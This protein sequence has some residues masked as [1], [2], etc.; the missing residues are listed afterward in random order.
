VLEDDPYAACQYLTIGAQ[1]EVGRIAGGD[2]T[3]RDALTARPP[4]FAGV[5]SE[6]ALEALDVRAVLM[7]RSTADTTVRGPGRPTVTFVLKRTVP[8]ES[9][10]FAAPAAAS[11]I[12][13][14][15]PAI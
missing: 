13:S 15:R 14:A 7:G 12:A 3:C 10:A 5:H 2:Q 9:A 4:S 1:E 8:A 6:G 11:R